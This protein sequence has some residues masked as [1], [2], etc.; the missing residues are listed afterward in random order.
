MISV[1]IPVYNAEPYLN[2]CIDS[3]LASTYRDFEIILVN[4]GSTDRSPDIC[5]AYEEND[6]RVIF[7]S[8]ENQG[9]SAARNHGIR[10]ARGEWLVF[11]DSDDFISDDF[12]E[13]AARPEYRQTDL[14][15]FQFALHAS[16]DSNASKDSGRAHNSCR[17]NPESSATPP[18]YFQGEDMLRFLRRI[19][20][21]SPLEEGGTLDFR[22]PCARAYRKS[23]LEEYSIRFSP[24]IRVGEDLLFNL[25]YQL[26]AKSCVFL[27]RDVYFY[28]L[29]GD[30]SSH[31]FNPELHENHALLLQAVRDVLDKNGMYA[32]LEPYFY[33]YALENLS[34]VL[35]WE[36]FS[37]KSPRKYLES[38]KLCLGMHENP[39]YR[40][41]FH[42]NRHAGILPRRIL[43][44][45]FRL[46]CF[47]LVKLISKA[48]F[49]YLGRS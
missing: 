27:P 21:P 45:C 15:L 46:K 2:R 31:H 10:K 6:S 18:H 43:V 34:Y 7:L 13:L 35:I 44:L 5:R 1:I 49:A 24:D 47:L 28:A 4:D 40:K 29:R 8:Q 48:S 16:R 25:E 32:S 9:V 26:K 39:F 22:T 11:L 33:S 30:S 14:I 38:R 41:A 36:I 37:P 3:V 20:V 23:I 42:Y 19:L 12:L 17:Q